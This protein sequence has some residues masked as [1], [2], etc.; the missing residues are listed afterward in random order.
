MGRRKGEMSEEERRKRS[1][2]RRIHDGDQETTDMLKFNLLLYNM[3]PIDHTDPAVLKDRIQAYFDLCVEYGRR[4]GAAG[5]AAAIGVTRVTL[6]SWRNGATRPSSEHQQIMEKAF[7]VIDSMM[8]Q[9]ML[10]GKVNP[11]SGIFLMANNHGYRQKVEI[12]AE[13]ER[14]Q[15]ET[16]SRAELEQRYNPNIIDAEIVQPAQIVQKPSETVPAAD[17]AEDDDDII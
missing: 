2:A 17:P 16:L 15:L 6:I 10:T 4:P 9:F 7:S 13:V 5:L 11:V 3:P 8:E 1:E 12:S 14:P